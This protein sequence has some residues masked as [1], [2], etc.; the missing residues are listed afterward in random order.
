MTCTDNGAPVSVTQ[1]A[2]FTL[3]SVGI[4]SNIVC[5]VINQQLQS[6]LR[7]D[8][9]WEINGVTYAETAQIPA[10]VKAQLKLSNVDQAWNTQK[11]YTIGTNVT[12]TETLAAGF[13]STYCT[14]DSATLNGPGATNKNILPGQSHATGALPAG[15]TTYTIKNVVTCKSEHHLGEVRAEQQRRQRRAGQLEPRCSTARLTASVTS[16][17]KS[18]VVPGTYTLSENG[19]PS[20]YSQTNLTCNVGMT[21]NQVTIAPATSVTC[22]FT[23][24]DSPATLTLQ[25]SVVGAPGVLPEKWTLTAKEGETVR[26]SGNGTATGPVKANTQFMP[27]RDRDRADQPERLHRQRLGLPDRHPGSGDALR[28]HP[29]RPRARLEHRVRDHEHRQDLRP[30]DHQDGHVVRAQR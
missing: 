28:R 10:S 16:G 4:G 29:A 30:D 22:T 21:G 7:V 17:T 26:L 8:K 25:K 1:A 24:V 3:P 5:T 20:G 23:N 9:T 14:L 13:P 6:L 2:S 27:L 18:V 19:G 12:I 11:S 15:L